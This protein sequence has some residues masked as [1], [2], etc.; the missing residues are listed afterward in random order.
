MPRSTAAQSRAPRRSA[1]ACFRPG[2]PGSI[3]W[4]NE[5]DPRLI[6][7]YGIVT[8]GWYEP[9]FS[10]DRFT[11]GVGLGL[12]IAVDEEREGDQDAFA[13]GI[14]TMTTS[15]R[16]GRDWTARF[17]WSRVLSNYDRDTDISLFGLG[18]RF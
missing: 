3:A 2:V 5:G 15:Y 18:Y 8:Q 11:L 7:R 17:T 6:G 1:T 16:V 13:A 12:Y 14:L 10:G 9:S 4:L